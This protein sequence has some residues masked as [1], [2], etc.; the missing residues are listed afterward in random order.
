MK[1]TAILTTAIFL[2]TTFAAANP[3]PVNEASDNLNILEAR[4]GCSGQRKNSDH[5]EH[6]EKLTWRVDI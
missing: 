1:P 2:F 4:K 3:A 5:C 6:P